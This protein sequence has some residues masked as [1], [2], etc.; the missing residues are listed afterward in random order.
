MQLRWYGRIGREVIEESGAEEEVLTQ[1]VYSSEELAVEEWR[2]GE[3]G[4]GEEGRAGEETGK[5]EAG[6]G[7]K[8]NATAAIICGKEK[9]RGRQWEG[10]V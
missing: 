6:E 10:T 7:R 2:G 1:V 3:G 9:E 5:D 8:F 4:E